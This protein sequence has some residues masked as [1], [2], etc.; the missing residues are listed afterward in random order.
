LLIGHSR[1]SGPAGGERVFSGDCGNTNAGRA[2]PTR[3]VEAGSVIQK[4]VPIEISGTLIGIALALAAQAQFGITRAHQFPTL[5]AG[6]AIADVRT[7]QS[8][9]LPEFETST[10]RSFADEIE[11]M[12]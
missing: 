3:E 10:S 8:K 11:T 1:R 2:I 6:S 9:F 7:A 4:D 12:E 5:S